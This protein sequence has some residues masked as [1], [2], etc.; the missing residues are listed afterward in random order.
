MENYFTVRRISILVIVKHLA[1]VTWRHTHVTFPNCWRDHEKWI[2]SASPGLSTQ[3]K[4]IESSYI[5]NALRLQNWMSIGAKVVKRVK[6]SEGLP[7]IALLS[8]TLFDFAYWCLMWLWLLCRMANK[9]PLS[10]TRRKLISFGPILGVGLSNDFSMVAD[11][12]WFSFFSTSR[13]FLKVCS[14]KWKSVMLRIKKISNKSI[15][16]LEFQESKY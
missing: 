3:C 6:C 2:T 5:K 13:D 4:S 14:I 1:S 12:F 9:M 7:S 10:S 16:S 11:R 8:R 15:S